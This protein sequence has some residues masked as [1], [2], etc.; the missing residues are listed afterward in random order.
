[1]EK[2]PQRNR[3]QALFLL[4]VAR[5]SGTLLIGQ[6]KVFSALGALPEGLFVVTTRDC[7]SNV[8]KKLARAGDRVICHTLA[9]VERGE[10][11]KSLGVRSAQ[12]A[13]LPI[14]SGFAE[15]L[16]ELLRQ[17]GPCIYE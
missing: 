2:L 5:K 13:A 14:K 6:D 16:A 4:G 1:M 11:G 15:K 8:L 3:R 9:G 7:S 17:E 12:V 10:L